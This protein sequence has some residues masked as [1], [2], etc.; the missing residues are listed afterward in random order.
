MEYPG[1]LTLLHHHI[2]KILLDDIAG[3]SFFAD[4]ITGAS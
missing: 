1:L 2:S 3:A 4:D